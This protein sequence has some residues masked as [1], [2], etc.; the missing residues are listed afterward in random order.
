[1]LKVNFGNLMMPH[2]SESGELLGFEIRHELVN[3]MLLYNNLDH[4]VMK[5]AVRTVCYLNRLIQ[6]GIKED[7]NLT[8]GFDN[9]INFLK[10]RKI[11]ADIQVNEMELKEFGMGDALTPRS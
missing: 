10:L 3:M 11:D 2:F 8:I 9:S 6:D 4:E 7:F 1:M 5:R